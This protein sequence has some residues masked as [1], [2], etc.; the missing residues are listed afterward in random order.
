VQYTAAVVVPLRRSSS[1]KEA[2]DAGGVRRIGELLLLDEGVP[3][4]PFDKLRAVGRD[5]LGLRVVDVGIDQA[6][7][8]HA[9]RVV[10]D[11]SAGRHVRQQV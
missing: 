6:G 2:R 8:D 3:V 1:R 11:R 7:Q 5:H 4:Q 9:V 10:V